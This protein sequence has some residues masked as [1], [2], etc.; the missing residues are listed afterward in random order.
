MQKS[1]FVHIYIFPT[2][3]LK[4]SRKV[5]YRS[6]Y[7]YFIDK[8]LAFYVPKTSSFVFLSISLIHWKAICIKVFECVGRIDFYL[9]PDYYLNFLPRVSSLSLSEG[10]KGVSYILPITSVSPAVEAAKQTSICAM[11]LPHIFWVCIF[12][13]LHTAASP[14]PR[15][16][17]LL[18][19]CPFCWGAHSGTVRGGGKPCLHVPILGRL[20]CTC[21]AAGKL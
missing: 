16:S 14:C 12:T 15:P 7:A 17:S 19:G 1:T 8:A 3:S 6:S 13:Q 18:Q 10:Y 9:G 11:F 20:L 5:E 21:D 4:V 2:V